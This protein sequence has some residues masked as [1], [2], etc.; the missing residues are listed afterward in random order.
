MSLREEWGAQSFSVLVEPILL[1]VN[2]ATLHEG[3]RIFVVRSLSRF[4]Q[5][6]PPDHLIFGWDKVLVIVKIEPNFS[7]HLVSPGRQWQCNF[8]T[9]YLDT[10]PNNNESKET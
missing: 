7:L 10:V 8:A 1:R 2:H 3:L 9:L 5:Y 6:C 4:D